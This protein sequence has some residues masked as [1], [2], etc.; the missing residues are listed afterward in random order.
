[1]KRTQSISLGRQPVANVERKVEGE[2]VDYDGER[3]YRIARAEAMKPF[4]MSI[5]SDTNHWLFVASNGGLTAGRQSPKF[6]LF[7]YGTEDK[8]VDAAGTTG[9]YTAI[10]ATRAGTTHLWHPFRDVGLLVYG[11]TRRLS[12]S[13][14]GNRVVFEEINEELELAFRYEWKT[15][16]RF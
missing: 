4:F 1:M 2:L 8:I 10:L 11:A 12:K 7:P 3:F 9:P 13:V 6:A 5:V 15:S 16:D 14:L